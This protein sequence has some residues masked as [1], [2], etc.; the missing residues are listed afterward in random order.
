ML[1]APEF[2]GLAEDLL[3][4]MTS[5]AYSAIMT[6]SFGYCCPSI[7]LVPVGDLFNHHHDCG[8]HYLVS[9]SLEARPAFGYQ[10][11]GQLFDLSLL[12]IK[13]PEQ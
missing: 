4:S 3:W 11:K 8:Q 1:G 10:P 9:A 12:G 5:W 7:C 13:K 6:R 2:E